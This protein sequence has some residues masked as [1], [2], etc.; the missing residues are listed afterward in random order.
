MFDRL[1]WKPDRVLL[2]DLV[3]RLEH[4]KNDD[5][6]LGE[7]CFQFYKTDGLVM[8]YAE[9]LKTR[10]DFAPSR[11]FE[12]GI[13]DGGSI[14]FWFELFHPSKHVAL[15]LKEKQNSAYFGRYLE[16]RGLQ[17]KIRTYWGINQADGSKVMDIYTR[18]FDGPL[19]LV[20]DDASHLYGP[21]KASFE[22][23]FPLLRPGGLYVIED[24]AWG[25][26]AEYQKPDH[27]WANE[28]PLTD[29]VLE[30]IECVGGPAAPIRRVTV[31]HGFVVVERAW[32]S[33][34]ELVDFKLGNY[35]VRRAK[36]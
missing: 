32:H 36:V 24:W 16:S 20:I 13:W 1:V 26:W 31:S 18:E 33:Q 17:E 9:Y 25:H 27:P 35:I 8:E 5:W 21:T 7:L 34:A 14:A 22:T 10:P 12:L 29:L 23:L 19:D 15:D 6:E 4:F 30:L 11:V 2:D 3:F 28:I